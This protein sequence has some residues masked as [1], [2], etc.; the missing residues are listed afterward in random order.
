MEIYVGEVINSDKFM[1]TNDTS[2]VAGS[3]FIG[4]GYESNFW[5]GF[6]DFNSSQA[7]YTVS[8]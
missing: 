4:R 5:P 8:S 6:V 2:F 7:N 3:G 1:A